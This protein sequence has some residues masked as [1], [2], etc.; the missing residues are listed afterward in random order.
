MQLPLEGGATVFFLVRIRCAEA[1]EEGSGEN[2]GAGLSVL[3]TFPFA[4]QVL[5][6]LEKII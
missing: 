6:F 1:Q 4:F 2:T 5:R 3:S